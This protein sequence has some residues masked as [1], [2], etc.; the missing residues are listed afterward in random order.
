MALSGH[1]RQST[2][3][4]VQIGPFVDDTDGK[5]SET[6][7]TITSSE[8][9]ISKNGANIDA[10]NDATA[11]TTDEIGMYFCP[12]E[13]SHTTCTKFPLSPGVS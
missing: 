10:K 9:R 3:V 8:V 7:L 5:T 11:A 4:T 6:G 13:S 1:L 2:A 12:D